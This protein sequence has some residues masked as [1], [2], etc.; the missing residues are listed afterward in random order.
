MQ[1]EIKPIT[2]KSSIEEKELFSWS[3]NLIKIKRRKAVNDKN[4]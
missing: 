3:T 2:Q 1:D 4:I